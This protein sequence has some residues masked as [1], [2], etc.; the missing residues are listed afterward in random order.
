MR[1]ILLVDNDRHGRESLATM[2]RK[3]I[4]CPVL[5]AETPEEALAVLDSQDVSLLI[6][7]LFPPKNLGVEL[8]KSVLRK[9][10]E[11]V[12]VVAVP[13]GDR[14]AMV[15]ILQAG[16][17][18]YLNKPV[19]FDEAIIVAA[20]SLEHHDLQIHKEKRGPKIRKTEGFHGIIGQASGMQTLFGMIERVAEDG[21]STVLI[22]GESGTGKEM[23]AKALHA[24]SPRAGKNFVPLNCAAIPDDLLESEL[25]GYVKGAFTGANQSKQGR[26]QYAEG[27]TLFLDEIGDMKPALQAKLLRVLQEKEFEPVGGVKPIQADVRIVAATHRHLEDAVKKGLFREDLYYRLSVVPLQIP[28]LRERKEDIPLLIEKFMQVYNRGRKRGLA[29]FAGDALAALQNYAWPGNVRELENLVQRLAI[30]HADGL[31]TAADLPEKYRAGVDISAVAEVA[32]VL[33]SVPAPAPVPAP[34]LPAAA[35]PLPTSVTADAPAEVAPLESPADFN[36]LVSD[37]EDRLILQA[38]SRTGG[39]KKEAAELLNLKRTTLLEK[40]KKK[41]LDSLLARVGYKKD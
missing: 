11:V 15:R 24:F 6:T 34:E 8:V 38:L 1:S 31:V 19:D 16:A 2:L 29:G 20:R 12:S 9:N 18:F 39:N 5:E 37:F 30:L 40:I 4:D 32:P 23:V 33:R 13:A 36:T 3:D 7:D 41:Q 35:V 28:P 14:E 25:F 21:E 26:I 22:Q 17:L 27:G 10:P